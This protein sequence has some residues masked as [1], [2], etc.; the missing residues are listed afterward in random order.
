MS[1]LNLEYP[2]PGTSTARAGYFSAQILKPIGS[3]LSTVG[4][5][6]LVALATLMFIL[7][8]QWG[9]EALTILSGSMQ[10]TLSAGDVAAVRPVPVSELR[11]GMI[12][13]YA[14][15]GALITHR[16]VDFAYQGGERRIITKGDSNTDPDPL[17][18]PEQVRGRV[19]YVIPKIGG[20]LATVRGHI[21][22]LIG[23]VTLYWLVAGAVKRRRTAQAEAGH[24]S[25]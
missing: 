23:A 14:T 8:R 25:R 11:P 6:V 16:I 2:V 19:V 18:K 10:P 3:V 24:G 15:N 21:T 9:G 7:P 20:W 1:A 22:Y 4:V 12:I 17:V 13:T 5:L